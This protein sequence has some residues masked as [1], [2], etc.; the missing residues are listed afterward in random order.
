MT[1]TVY[2]SHR[3]LTHSCSQSTSKEGNLRDLCTLFLALHWLLGET[4]TAKGTEHGP[5]A[6]FE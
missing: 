4:V 5:A 6:T 1:E 3:K 2:L